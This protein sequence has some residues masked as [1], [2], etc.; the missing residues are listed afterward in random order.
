MDEKPPPGL[1]ATKHSLLISVRAT[2][3][4]GKNPFSKASI[5]KL[6]DL[7]KERHGIVVGRR[8]IFQ[9][10]KDLITQ[11]L[12][13]RQPRYNYKRPGSPG[14]YSSM[15][16][17]TLEGA[18]YLLNKYVDGA[19]DIF[20]RVLARITGEDKRWPSPRH[21]LPGGYMPDDPEQKER[22][23]QLAAIVAKDIT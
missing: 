14:Q 15:L 4:Q 8:W 7:L 6:R 21:I 12:L 9:C 23:K 18:R 10:I 20:R 2:L 3:S 16:A 19:Y 22:L 11:G 5:N 1:N 17:F 13:I